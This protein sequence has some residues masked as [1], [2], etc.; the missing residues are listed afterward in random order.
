MAEALGLVVSVTQL[1][2]LSG[3]LLAGGYGFLSKVARAPSE[4]RSLLTEAAAIDSLLGQLQAIAESM[5]KATS[6]DALQTLARLGVFEECSNTLR[7]IRKALKTCEQTHDRD[8]KNIGKRLLWPFKE[9]ET[10]ESLE[11]LHHLRGLLANAVE[12]NSAF[13]FRY[14]TSIFANYK[15]VQLYEDLKQVKNFSIMNLAFYP[16]TSIR[17]LAAKRLKKSCHGLA[18]PPQTAPTP[19]LKVPCLVVCKALGF[20]S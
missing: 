6:N 14:V 3:S 5:P 18:Q 13:V 7:S 17:I 12:A 15:A 8:A 1:V 10:K 11:R 4:M 16:L 19:A 20:G 9:R 2:Q